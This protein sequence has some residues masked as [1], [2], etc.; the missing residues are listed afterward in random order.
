MKFLSKFNNVLCVDSFDHIFENL[1]II[2]HEVLIIETTVD[3]QFNIRE[4]FKHDNIEYKLVSLF[5]TYNIQNGCNEDWDG[6]VYSRHS[7]SDLFD[8]WWYQ[9]RHDSMAVH[10]NRIP[11]YFNEEFK[12]TFAYVK[13]APLDIKSLSSK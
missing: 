2:S 8:G 4:S 12:Y 1:D 6:W 10:A 11:S 5:T 13:N 9:G 7:G 3:S